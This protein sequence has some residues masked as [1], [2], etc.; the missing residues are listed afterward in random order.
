M[1]RLLLNF[2]RATQSWWQGRTSRP[3]VG[4]NTLAASPELLAKQ[5]ADFDQLQVSISYGLR[6]FQGPEGVARLYKLL[7]EVFGGTEAGGEW[8]A[9]PAD[10]QG[11]GVVVCLRAAEP[12]ATE[13]VPAVCCA[14][15]QLALLFSLMGSELQ[16]TDEIARLVA[17]TDD[18][19]VHSFE[20]VDGGSGYAVRP[21]A[22][23]RPCHAP[24]PAPDLPSQTSDQPMRHASDKPMRDERDHEEP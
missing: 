1:S 15:R 4:R 13:G 21:G 2:D 5:T 6:S 16:P 12:R 23:M 22:A 20:V 8:P 24:P 11:G 19:R 7:E 17:S 14:D 18:A 10:R 9:A 3:F